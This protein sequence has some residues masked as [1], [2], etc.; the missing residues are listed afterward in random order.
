MSCPPFDGWLNAYIDTGG[1]RALWT[2]ISGHKNNRPG[3]AVGWV[4]R[5]YIM[6]SFKIDLLTHAHTFIGENGLSLFF[7]TIVCSYRIAG[8]CAAS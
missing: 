3:R 7:I 8:R 6:F 5:L 2:V 1:G 4:I